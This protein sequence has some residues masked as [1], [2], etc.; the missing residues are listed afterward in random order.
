M[1][2][3]Q[4][5]RVVLVTGAS[6][7]FGRAIAQELRLRGHRVYGTSRNPAAATGD[8]GTLLAMDVDDDASVAAGVA[9][10]LAN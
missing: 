8:C 9:Q 6:S 5:P 3:R 1:A 10:V 4:G 2:I 7:G